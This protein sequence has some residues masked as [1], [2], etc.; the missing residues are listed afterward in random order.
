MARKKKALGLGVGSGQ[1]KQKSGLFAYLIFILVIAGII[2]AGNYYQKNKTSYD[3][4]YGDYAGQAIDR[5][6]DTEDKTRTIYSGSETVTLNEYSGEAP[7][8][9]IYDVCSALHCYSG[10][11]HPL[12]NSASCKYYK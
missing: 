8:G 10:G 7:Q 12:C 5:Q 11:D 3:S 2:A 1:Q 4:S 6:I 9:D